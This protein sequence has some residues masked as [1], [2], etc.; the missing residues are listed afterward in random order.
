MVTE[1]ETK[2][3]ISVGLFV[4]CLADLMRPQVAFAAVTLLE[5]AGCRVR[6]PREQSCC[7]Q[8]TLNSGDRA[9]TTDIAKNVIRAFTRDDYVVTPSGSCADTLINKYP[10]LFRHDVQWASRAQSL[11]DK[12]FELTSFL[13]EKLDLNLEGIAYPGVCTY[14]DSC[15]GLRELGIQQQPRTLLAGVEGLALSELEDS[16]VCCGFGGLFSVKYPDISGRIVSDKCAQIT[17][18]D[19]DTVLGGDLG[20]LLNIA[21]RL[22]REGKRLKVFHIAEVLAGMTDGPAIG[23]AEDET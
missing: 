18:T 13:T 22:R 8:P 10:T 2:P 14:H 4:T 6:V 1:I 16:S 21:G 23:E 15:S 11:A 17:Q 5:R 12:T 7:G 20:C 19:A 9:S 3:P